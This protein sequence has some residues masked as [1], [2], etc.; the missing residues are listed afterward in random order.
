MRRILLI[1]LLL[2]ARPAWADTYPR[3]PGV[4]ALHYVFRISFGDASDEIEGD[5]SIRVRFAND[6]VKEIV[7]DLAT[8]ADGKGMTVLTASRGGQAAPFEHSNDRLRLP[9]ASP[10][11]AG[12]EE[13]FA[14]RYRGVPADGLRLLANIHG[15]R[16]A[17]SENWPD[18]AR[19]WLPMIDHPSDKATGEFIVT[20]PAHY[21]VVANGVLAE[22]LDLANGLRR[23]HWIQGVPIAS[24]LYAVG[25]AR[26]AVHHAGLVKGVQLQTWVF[27]QDREK[28]YPLFEATSRQAIEFFSE[29]VGP[30]SYEKLANVE[31]AG[32]N[33][34]TEHASAIF[35]GEKGV[36]VGRAPVV[37]EIA[38][39]WFG[40]A[41]TERDWDDVW[42]SEGFATYFTLLFTEHAEGREAFVLGLRQSRDRVLDL[43]KRLPDVPIV[44]RNLSDMKKVLNQLVYQ[45]GGW[46]LHMLRAQVG[47]EVFWAGIRDYYRRYR[48]KNASTAEFRR[49]MEEA[50]GQELGWFFAQWLNRSGVPRLEGSWRYDAAAKTIEVTLAQTQAGAPFRL[51]IELG[52]GFGSAPPRL[53]RVELKD[54][55]ATFKILADAEPTAVSL[56]PGTWLLMEAGPFLKSPTP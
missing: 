35:Y 42:L 33:G 16:T 20:A 37:H 51:P 29:S 10:S 46:T 32:I 39:Q 11:K 38:H 8:P 40:N 1:A 24:W 50:S 45:K 48:D 3:Q 7:L 17:F 28:G 31:A 34:G 49:V 41:V 14:I 13:T 25:A 54:A 47:S 30:F 22:E 6:G 52:V 26:F 53:E 4:D 12:Q 2:F 43:E 55:R 44:H 21:Q 15:E 56:D 9:L 27:P 36:T 5:A 19:Q 18:K 23:T